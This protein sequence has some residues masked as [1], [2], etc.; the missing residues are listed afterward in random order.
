[1]RPTDLGDLWFVSLVPIEPQP[2]LA[3][4]RHFAIA[5]LPEKRDFTVPVLGRR[6]GASTLSRGALFCFGLAD[7]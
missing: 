1:M 6:P 2:T 3:P 5:R 4:L 7:S